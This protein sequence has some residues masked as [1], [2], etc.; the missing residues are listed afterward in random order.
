MRSL[1]RLAV[2]SLSAIQAAAIFGS[3]V[4]SPNVA[5]SV[6]GVSRGGGLFGG[7]GKEGATVVE[8]K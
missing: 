2:L 7:N 8:K 4:V 6:F 3:S 1:L 5:S